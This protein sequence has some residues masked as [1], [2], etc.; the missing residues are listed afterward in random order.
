M[1]LPRLLPL[2]TDVSGIQA[3]DDNLGLPPH[4]LPS[5]TV[6]HRPLVAPQRVGRLRRNL[7]PTCRGCCLHRPYA[8]IGVP[9]GLLL[10]ELAYYRIKRGVYLLLKLP[11][12][13]LH[14]LVDPVHLKDDQPHQRDGGNRNQAVYFTLFHQGNNISTLA[15]DAALTFFNGHV[16]AKMGQKRHE[17][18]CRAWLVCRKIITSMTKTIG[19]INYFLD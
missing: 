8:A 5:P 12:A 15:K 11:P 17:G 1:L 3:T 6:D 9:V 13:G 2:L 14:T 18:C 10:L 7:R 19:L 4:L 16:F